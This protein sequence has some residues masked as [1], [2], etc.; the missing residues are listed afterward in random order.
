MVCKA[1]D[2]AKSYYNKLTEMSLHRSSLL[3]SL[4]LLPLILWRDEGMSEPLALSLSLGELPL[5][6]H[7]EILARSLSLSPSL[8]H[9]QTYYNTKVK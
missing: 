6:I 5:E 9:Q 8:F 7:R 4:L 1:A 2:S 3:T